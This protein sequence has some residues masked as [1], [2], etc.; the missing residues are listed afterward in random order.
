MI[1]I[2]FPLKTLIVRGL[3]R[4]VSVSQYDKANGEIHHK[5]IFNTN[6]KYPMDMLSHINE[7][8]FGALSL[9]HVTVRVPTQ[10]KEEMDAF[11]KYYLPIFNIPEVSCYVVEEENGAK[12]VDYFLKELLAYTRIKVVY[13]RNDI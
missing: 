6:T 8:V 5:L 4:D 10:D 13:L 12:M 3:L 2:T 11:I 9:N 1:A 7:P